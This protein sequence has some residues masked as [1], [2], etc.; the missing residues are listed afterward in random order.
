MAVTRVRTLFATIPDDHPW[1]IANDS[2]VWLKPRRT[3]YFLTRRQ[4]GRREELETES[5]RLRTWKA[6]EAAEKALTQLENKGLTR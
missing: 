2:P 1:R 5:G 4:N 3:I 6:R